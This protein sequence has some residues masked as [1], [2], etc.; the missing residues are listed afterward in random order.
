MSTP[1]PIHVLRTSHD[2]FASLAAGLDA[3]QVTQQSYDDEWTIADVASHL[4]SGAEIFTAMATA[5]VAG[6]PVPGNES[7]PPIWDRWNATPPADQVRNAVRAD[8]L[9]VGLLEGLSPEQRAAF[10]M[11]LFGMPADLE[12]LAS[13]RL[14]EHALHTWDIAVA[15][16]PS[17]V[18]P[19][20]AVDVLS[21]SVLGMLGFFIKPVENGGIVTITTTDPAAE[22]SFDLAAPAVLDGPPSEPRASV[23]MPAEAF[24]R[25]VYGRLDAEHTP[26]GVEA[27]EATLTALRTAFPGF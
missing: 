12:R 7:F 15:L 20:D 24:L 14:G 19:A 25:L 17:A 23:S 16:D 3:E 18:V 1:D 9:F 8:E 22:H 4:G 21:T 5:V 11:E 10:S 13:M 6:E 2:R 26:A 27:D